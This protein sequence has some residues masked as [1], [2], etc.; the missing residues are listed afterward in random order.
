MKLGEIKEYEDAK[1]KLAVPIQQSN[2]VAAKILDEY[3][4]K[5][6]TIE[7]PDIETIIRFI[8]SA[9]KKI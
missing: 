6:I 1:V 3:E 8:F 2:K 7:D 4:V 9:K 5:D